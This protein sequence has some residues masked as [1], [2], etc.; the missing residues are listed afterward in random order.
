MFYITFANVVLCFWKAKTLADKQ[1]IKKGKRAE[2]KAR[3]EE[4]PREKPI[5]QKHNGSHEVSEISSPAENNELEITAEL[6]ESFVDF[7]DQHQ[8]ELK[9]FCGPWHAWKLSE[10]GYDIVVTSE[11]VYEPESLPSLC[12]VLTTAAKG[13]KDAVPPPASAEGDSNIT[14]VACKRVYFG[15][16]GGEHAFK[17]CIAEKGASVREVW[18]SGKGVDRTVLKV[19]W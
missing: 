1:N 16:G 14:L 5:F 7:L 3:D 9:F 19:T 15:V 6:V 11:T 17:E 2:G 8:I 18:R 13:G 4:T 12:Q 10:E